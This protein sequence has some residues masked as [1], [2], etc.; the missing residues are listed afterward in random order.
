MSVSDGD[1]SKEVLFKERQM[2]Q[3]A[4]LRVGLI[5]LSAFLI[6]W[7]LYTIYEQFFLNVPVGDNPMSDVG[8][9][10]TVIITL[11]IGIALPIVIFRASLLVTVDRED[12]GISFSPFTHRTIPIK[13]IIYCEPRTVVPFRDYGGFGIR[14]SFRGDG[15][16]YIMNGNEGVQIELD[17]G[18]RLFVGSQYPEELARAVAVARSM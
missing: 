3:Q 11:A 16:A 9:L 10:I 8:L 12:L 4:W 17:D 15:V 18:K 7:S 5:V 6:A 2:F 13:S 1:K 14:I